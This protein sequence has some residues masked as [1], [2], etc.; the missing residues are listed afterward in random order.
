MAPMVVVPSRNAPNRIG[1]RANDAV[2]IYNIRRP[3][4][5]R[6]QCVAPRMGPFAANQHDESPM[7]QTTTVNV[8]TPL[9]AQPDHW[10]PS[11][12]AR[13]THRACG[14][15]RGCPCHLVR[16]C[17]TSLLRRARDHRAMSRGRKLID[18]TLKT[19][20]LRCK[21]YDPRRIRPGRRWTV[22]HASRPTLS[23][24]ERVSSWFGPSILGNVEPPP[25]L[26]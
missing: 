19:T 15:G 6:V 23:P 14:D 18:T 10:L 7:R 2:P 12:A 17:D 1:S 4:A 24:H 21:T 16:P 26:T 3:R 8:L 13:R 9:S 25:C 20:R 5:R 11:S 22:R